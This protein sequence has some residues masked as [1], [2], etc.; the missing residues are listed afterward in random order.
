MQPCSGLTFFLLYG[1]LAGKMNVLVLNRSKVIPAR[2]VFEL[3]GKE[4]EIFLLRKISSDTYQVL[5]RPGRVFK[6]GF[7]FVLGGKID[8]VV[9]EILEDFEQSEVI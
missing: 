8:C 5:V 6:L 9:E 4:R 1:S 3:D 7:S 2:I